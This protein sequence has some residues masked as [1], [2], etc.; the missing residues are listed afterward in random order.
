MTWDRD[1]ARVIETAADL[2][3]AAG[4][5]LYRVA[6]IADNGGTLAAYVVAS[7]TPGAAIPA[8]QSHHREFRPMLAVHTA[9][10][11]VVTIPRDLV[12][13]MTAVA[14]ALLDG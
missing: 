2:H 4:S 6:A 10:Y 7:R 1:P 11:V 3:A 14:D 5:P 12:D 9:R 13:A 8:A